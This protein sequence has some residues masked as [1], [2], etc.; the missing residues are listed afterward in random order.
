LNSVSVTTS[1]AYPRA[2]VWRQLGVALLTLSVALG[3][4]PS[5]ASGDAVPPDKAVILLTPKF[6]PVSFSHQRHATELAIACRDCHHAWEQ[7]PAPRP[8]HACH[9]ARH[10]RIAATRRAEA[11][12]QGES[13]PPVRAKLAFH[14][15]CL[16]CHARLADKQLPTGPH[17]SCR[18]CHD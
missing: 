6:G 18:D 14:G 7:Q 12:E 10:Y 17:D 9:E 8:C 5:S 3:S 15:L 11:E 2:I 13:P 4:V 1:E 16:D